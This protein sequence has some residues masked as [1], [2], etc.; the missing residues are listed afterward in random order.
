MVA[1]TNRD[2]RLDARNGRFRQDLLFRLNGITIDLPSLRERRSEIPIL[3]GHFLEKTRE[4]YGHCVNCMS[5]EAVKALTRYHWPGNIREL[6]NCIERAVALAREE[7][8]HLKDLPDAI[9]SA[10]V[11]GWTEKK[12][13][14]RLIEEAL[15]RFAGDKTRP[16]ESIGWNRQ[17][18][19]RK[20]EQY[21][22][23]RDFGRR[24]TA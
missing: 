18:L 13:E 23:P 15:A 12:G 4:R 20:M 19:Y 2:L 16:A 5:D 10:S 11:V 8:I 21:N 3:V 14:H 9:R 6:E 24:N 17:K 1:A 7:T 22:I